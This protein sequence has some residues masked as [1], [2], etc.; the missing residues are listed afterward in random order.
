[1]IPLLAD[2]YSVALPR[3]HPLAARDAVRL[4]DLAEERWTLP[5]AGA[6]HTELLRRMCLAEGFEPQIAFETHD[7]AMAQPLV[8]AGLAVSLLPALGLVPRHAGVAVRPLAGSPLA[9][10]VMAVRPG[11]I[12]APVVDA[13]QAALERSA[14]RRG[15]RR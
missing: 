6:S 13:M 11:R 9:R 1:M 10:Q 7:I 8:A 3:D 12:R 14:Q 5:P 15:P 2:P 4:A